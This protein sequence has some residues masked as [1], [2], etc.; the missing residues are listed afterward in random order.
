MAE[1]SLE[2]ALSSDDS[3]EWR[4]AILSEI[5]SLVKNE[6]WDIVRKPKDRSVVSCRYVLTT[7][8]NVDMTTKKKARLVAKGVQSTLWYRL[9][10]NVCSCCEA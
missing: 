5:K 1:M 4:E 7:K 8:L 10:S 3:E 2:Q 6:T 9:P